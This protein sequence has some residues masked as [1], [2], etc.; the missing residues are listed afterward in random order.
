MLTLILMVFN[1]NITHVDIVYFACRGRKY[2]TMGYS[3]YD[4]ARC[5][6][7]SR[8]QCNLFLS[9]F[10]EVWGGFL[11]HTSTFLK[12]LWLVY[13]FFHF[14]FRIIWLFTDEYISCLFFWGIFG[15]KLLF[16]FYKLFCYFIAYSVYINFVQL[17]TFNNINKPASSQIDWM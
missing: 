6:F 7:F 2:T 9:Y 13:I 10:G 5:V 11:L 4:A 8:W 15:N 17:W 16:H 3:M 1:I 12:D 14:T